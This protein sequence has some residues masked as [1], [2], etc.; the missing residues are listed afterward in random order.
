[1]SSKNKFE[2]EIERTSMMI[3]KKKKNNKT[4]PE[5]KLRIVLFIVQPISR[6]S[7]SLSFSFVA[8]RYCLYDFDSSHCSQYP[9][10]VCV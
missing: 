8:V 4:N 2:I 6:S 9:S 10:C 3:K 5:T 1:M 7:L